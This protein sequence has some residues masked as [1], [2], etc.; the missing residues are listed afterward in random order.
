MFVRVRS[1]ASDG[2]VMASK[3]ANTIELE[4]RSIVKTLGHQLLC[5][6]GERKR[7]E[8]KNEEGLGVI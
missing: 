4:E 5:N 2:V 1:A 6:I 7:R 8:K 3:I